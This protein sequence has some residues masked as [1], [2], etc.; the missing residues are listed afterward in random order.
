MSWGMVAVFLFFLVKINFSGLFF[1]DGRVD[2]HW[3][4]LWGGVLVILV[5][6]YGRALPALFFPPFV[7]CRLSRLAACHVISRLCFFFR[8]L[9]WK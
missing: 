9:L 1:W 2:D 8:F 3:K 6:D 4:G 5:K 7:F